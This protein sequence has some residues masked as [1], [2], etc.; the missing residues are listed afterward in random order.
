MEKVSVVISFSG[1]NFGAYVPILP[2]CVAT[3]ATPNEVR[4]NIVEAIQF[5]IEGSLED[6]D[7]LDPV[8]NNEYELSFHFD[9]VSLLNYY[10]GVL[11][12][13]GLEKITGVNQKQLQHYAT[14]LKKPR[15]PQL[16][17]I[18]KS[19]HDFGKELMLLEL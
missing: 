8:F 17:K 4:D 18:E 5:H 16:D 13:S 14:G 1:K 3:G 2:G 10:K 7:E 6:G 15:K 9:A 19:L 12:L 11:T